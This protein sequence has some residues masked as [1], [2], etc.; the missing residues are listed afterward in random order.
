MG[1]NQYLYKLYNLSGPCIALEA[2]FVN[3]FC[4]VQLSKML[5]ST[6]YQCPISNSHSKSGIILFS[7]L[8]HRNIPYLL[9]QPSRI[10]SFVFLP[11][12]SSPFFRIYFHF[13]KKFQKHLLCQLLPKLVSA[14]PSVRTTM[15][16][17]LSRGHQK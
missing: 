10:S 6:I 16:S 3:V 11:L 2:P 7:T 14:D 9:L 1:S 12:C 13:S 8:L 5:S 17:L 15:G 4:S